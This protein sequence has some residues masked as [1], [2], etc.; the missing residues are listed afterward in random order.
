MQS[1][2][3]QKNR[4][5]WAIQKISGLCQNINKNNPA[6]YRDPP[7]AQEPK[8]LTPVVDEAKPLTPVVDDHFDVGYSFANQQAAER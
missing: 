7:A 8:P 1:K 6:L 3:D 5:N 4:Y 2:I